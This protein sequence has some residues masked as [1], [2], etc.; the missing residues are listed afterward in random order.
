[1][2]HLILILLLP[3]PI[4]A[5]EGANEKPELPLIGT[6]GEPASLWPFVFL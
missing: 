6:H 3:N 4:A 1:M 5:V 2:L